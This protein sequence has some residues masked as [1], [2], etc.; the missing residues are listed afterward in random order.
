[1]ENREVLVKKFSY[2]SSQFGF[3]RALGV[4]EKRFADSGLDNRLEHLFFVREVRI[5]GS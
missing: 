5:E 2:L 1:M 4:R 3:V